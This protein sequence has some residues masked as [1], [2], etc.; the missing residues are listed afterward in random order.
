MIQYFPSGDSAFL[1]KF[2]HEISP[3]INERIRG[4]IFLLNKAK[5]AG[6]IEVVPSYTDLLVHYRNQST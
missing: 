3:Q 4:F 2:G 6:I 1:L 5:I